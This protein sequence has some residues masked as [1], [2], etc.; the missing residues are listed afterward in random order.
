MIFS[1]LQRRSY[2]WR[3][4]A[5]LATVVLCECSDPG[6]RPPKK[7]KAASI[8]LTLAAVELDAEELL[9]SYAGSFDHEERR[10]TI[11][12]KLLEVRAPGLGRAADDINR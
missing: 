6:L 8:N 1:K 3:S 10:D 9:R 7:S 5:L 4:W 12:A 11:L 2:G